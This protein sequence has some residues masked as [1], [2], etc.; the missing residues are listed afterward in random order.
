MWKLINHEWVDVPET[1]IHT[2]QLIGTCE[3]CGK[4]NI[5]VCQVT[6]VVHLDLQLHKPS[7]MVLGKTDRIC[8]DCL[9]IRL[10]NTPTSSQ[11]PF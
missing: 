7:S 8:D 1:I 6:A 10:E 5:H 9:K 2:P 11:E 3:Q 4:E